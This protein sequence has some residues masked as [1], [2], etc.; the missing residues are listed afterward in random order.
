MAKIIESKQNKILTRVQY[1]T[2]SAPPLS[3]NKD[4]WSDEELPISLTRE[5]PW[6]LLSSFCGKLPLYLWK[7]LLSYHAQ[8]IIAV[9]LY[10]FLNNY[11]NIYVLCC[12]HWGSLT[13]CLANDFHPLTTGG[14]VSNNC[15]KNSG[16]QSYFANF[17]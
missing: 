6:A 15:T 14:W 8:G 17:W 16:V 7:W 1:Y 9:L 13:N 2:S 12:A 5:I 11:I 3:Q 4:D 10:T